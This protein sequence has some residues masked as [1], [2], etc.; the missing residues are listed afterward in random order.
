MI[1]YGHE[2]AALYCPLASLGVS[3]YRIDP[4]RDPRW[5]RFLQTHP[6]ASIFHTPGWLE[7]LRRTYKYEPM[8]ITTCPPGRELTDGLVLCRVESWITGRR[9]VSLP[10][11]DHCEPLV[12][13]PESLEHL[14]CWPKRDLVEKDLKYLE[15]RPAS[16]RFENQSGF[17]KAKTFW[18]HKIDLRPS[19]DQL[20]R[21][22]HKTCVQRKVRI[23]HDAL[24]YEDGVSEELLKSF[25]R[26]VLVTRRRHQ[27]L[28]Q[29]L[30]WFRNLV[31]CLAGNAKLRL[32]F[33]AG[34]PVAGM[35]TLQFKDTV[36]YKYGCSDPAYHRFGG[37]QL[38]FWRTIQDAKE[39]GAHEFDLGR[40]DWNDTG[41]VTFKDRLGSTRFPISYMTWPAVPPRA[42]NL[43]GSL[44]FSKQVIG[45]LPDRILVSAGKLV[46]KHLG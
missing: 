36:V 8:A 34:Q 13:R 19:L 29:P 17:G 27:S 42:I 33:N 35:M 18:F 1:Y 32:V 28:P 2:L 38:L 22:F 20:F 30:S 43:A 25:Y 12:D 4:A 31:A 24:R 6:Y 3:L 40:S 26:L 46:Y 7:A 9:L 14:L 15:I 16:A 5:P 10:F 44:Q 45:I 23:G 39:G 37:M 41:L 21:R 11:A